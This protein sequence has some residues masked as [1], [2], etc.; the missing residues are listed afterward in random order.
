MPMLP[1]NAGR[2]VAILICAASASAF[3]GSE[4]KSDRARQLFLDAC[5]ACHTLERVKTQRL[6]AQEWRQVTAG[7]I[8]EGIALTDDEVTLVVEYLEKNFGPE[9]P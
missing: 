3:T 7:M 8:S 2:M 9:N 4:P 5:T 6:T 1:G